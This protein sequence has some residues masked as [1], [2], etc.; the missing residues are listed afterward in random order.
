MQHKNCLVCG[1]EFIKP[2]NCSV[3]DWLGGKKRPKGKQYCSRKCADKSK[4]GKPAWNKGIKIQTNTG[5]T[6]I[7]KGQRISTKTEF[8]KGQKP[9]NVGKKMTEEKYNKLKNSGFFNSKWGEKSGGWKGGITKLNLCIRT[10][11]EYLDWRKKVFERDNWTC[12][13]CNDKRIKGNRVILEAHHIKPFSLILKQNKI[14]STQEA[15][16]CKEIW[17]INNGQ[18]LCIPC[19]KQTK[20]YKNRKV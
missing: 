9:Y 5:R 6:W 1:K 20:S 12:I 4:F 11:K 3:V 2:V 19:H 16:N 15:M 14:K 8:H 17:D 10:I 7:K 18:T 13:K